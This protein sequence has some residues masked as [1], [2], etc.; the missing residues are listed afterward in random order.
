M[1]LEMSPPEQPCTAVAEMVALAVALAVVD[2]VADAEV[3][4]ETDA[5]STN[6]HTAK[7]TIIP[8]KHAENESTLKA[9][10]I[11]PGMMSRHATTAVS[12]DTSKPTGSTSNVPG[13]NTT[14]ST[15]AH[16]LPRSLQKEIAT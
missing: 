1:K 3:D 5:R 13:I 10:Q 6:A 12:Q 4:E 7:W 9:I 8:P 11:P 2:E 16:H 15:K 14:R